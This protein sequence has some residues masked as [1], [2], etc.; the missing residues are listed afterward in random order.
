M[1]SHLEILKRLN[2]ERYSS[3]QELADTLDVTRAT[4]H[5]C[6]LRLEAMGVSIERVRGKG[7]RL[8]R[9]LDLIDANKI[10]SN[11]SPEVLNGLMQINVL[12]QVD[13]TN[14]FISSYES[15]ATSHF[16]VVLAE[17]QSAGKGR[18]GR[19]WE[20]P[21]A[22][23]IY[24]S[25]LWT[26]QKS[27]SEVGALSPLLAISMV[28]ALAAMGIEGLGLKWPNDIYCHYKKLAGLLIECSGEVNG[29]TKMII[30]VGVN[31]HMDD[32]DNIHIDQPWT[33][34]LS[35]TPNTSVSRNDIVPSLL[36]HMVPILNKFNSDQIESLVEDWREWDI[37]Q[38]QQVVL[39]TTNKDIVGVARGIDETGRLLLETK[40][41]TQVFSA[42]DVS[43]RAHA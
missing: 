39:H 36:N 8:L 17:M 1:L 26:M 21:Y 31:V 7:Y 29:N 35:N 24:M 11:L 4:I 3:G 14:N 34:I 5:N 28:R 41:G 9:P 16:S 42:G 2:H 25:L 37:M 23:N 10:K 30:G 18:R 12:H 43:L 20:S 32:Q 40:Q 13:S 27:M 6:I 22:A 15:P 38:N 19:T 33:N